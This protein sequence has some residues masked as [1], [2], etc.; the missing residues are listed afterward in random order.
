MTK[1]VL[2]GAA[3]ALALAATA[4]AGENAGRS[5]PTGREWEQYVKKLPPHNSE[6]LD[7]MMQLAKA[8]ASVAF[9]GF[10]LNQE[11]VNLLYRTTGAP[12]KDPNASKFM[13][14]MAADF[15]RDMEKEVAAKP[16]PS[17]LFAPSNKEVWCRAVLRV[18]ERRDTK[19]AGREV[20]SCSLNET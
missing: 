8:G 11:A 15:Y 7:A 2:F 19:S 20:T 10:K 9:C 18:E 16:P 3:A 14:A 4:A 12:F 1:A 6:Q 5:W 13:Q 17:R